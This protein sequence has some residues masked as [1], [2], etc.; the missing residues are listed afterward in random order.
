MHSA[1]NV[2]THFR[3]QY[4]LCLE[5]IWDT[6]EGRMFWYNHH[7]STSTWEQPP[8][9]RRYGDTEAPVPWVVHTRQEFVKAEGVEDEALAHEHGEW[10]DVLSYWH[11]NGK[12]ELKRKPDGVFICE[13]CHYQLALR[14]CNDCRKRMCFGCHRELHL[15]PWGFDQNVKITKK[16]RIDPTYIT[17]VEMFKHTWK[18]IEPYRCEMCKTNKIMAA[19]DCADCKKKLCR[20]CFRRIHNDHEEN[21]DHRYV[22]I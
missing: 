11:V 13:L 22:I 18:H 14:Y 12:V 21:S 15:H 8:L 4:M 2:R 9:V 10:K 19:Y 17:G 7:T 6:Q 1:I 3:K 5:K 20:P 16:M